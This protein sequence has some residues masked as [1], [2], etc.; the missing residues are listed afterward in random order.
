[1]SRL[2]I[3]FTAFLFLLSSSLW[4]HDYTVRIKSSPNLAYDLQEAI[5]KAKPNTLILLPEGTYTF[6]D[7]IT[8]TASH[9]TLRGLGM[10]KTVLSFKNQPAG[11]QGILALA[12]ALTVEDLAIEDT[13]GDGLR[14]EGAKGVTIRRTRVE[15]TN[16][17]S[18]FNGA[19]GL[20]PVLS[21]NVL[22]EDSVVKGASDAGIYVGQS[23]HIVVR[24]NRAEFNVAGIEIEN[25][26]HA[27]VYE[28]H[29][30][31][32]T[33]GILIFDLPNLSQQGNYT[34]VYNNVIKNN[35]TKNFAPQ[36]NIVGNVPSGT[37]VM[38]LAT[39]NVDVF[40]NKIIGNKTVG[41]LIASYVALAVI[42]GRPIP[43]GYDP[44][45][46][47]INIRENT[48]K[49]PLGFYFDDTDVNKL[50]NFAHYLAFSP[51]P[52]IVFDGLIAS[53]QISPEICIK[54]NKRLL[55]APKFS[56]LQLG[57]E[58]TWYG[59]LI[60]I[61]GGPVSKDKKPYRCLNNP[62]DGVT[63]QPPI[64]VPPVED[65]YSE[66]E[67]AALCQ[68]P[69][70]G[71][72]WP[73]LVV[74]C[75]NLSDYR[76]FA[77]SAEPRLDA[78]GGGFPYDLTTPLFSD[79]ASKYRFLF[80][81]PNQAINYNDMSVL[82]FPEGSVIT[83]TFAIGDDVNASMNDETLLETRLLIKRKNGWK[84]LP[85]I[86]NEDQTAARLALG[87]G[88]KAI[89][90][91]DFDGNKRETQYG[92]PNANQCGSCH[93][94]HE[95]VKPIGPKA[96]LLNMPSPY[97]T[98]VHGSDNNQL[99]LMA[100][101]GLLRGLP[102]NGAWP[103]TAQ[104]DNPASGTLE[105]RAKAYLDVN[106]AH[107]HSPGGRAFGTGL[108]LNEEQAVD[109]RYGL[110]KSPVAAGRGS[111]GLSF[112]IAPGDPFASIL[113]FRMDSIDPAIR[114]PELGR[115]LNHN[116]A[117]ALIRDWITSLDAECE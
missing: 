8:I 15:W 70:T 82:D 17:P 112:D 64:P 78:N 61:P 80:V 117:N 87:G 16:G 29:T 26:I 59:E 18:E 48:I 69:G 63:L 2:G 77:N 1:M 54:D 105:Q 22:I 44:Y 92:I 65:E 85:Y 102:A 71:V 20:Y 66:E 4:A 84:A 45:P 37:G 14:V 34:R 31:N 91:I 106:C 101:R 100:D 53:E 93:S 49:R 47:F 9:L 60:G 94:N 103:R 11:A 52:E 13:A 81:P 50:I 108:L 21:E 6:A 115:T 12:D 38:V 19:Y 67:I 104:W 76:L 28:N 109:V 86:W 88:R 89:S 23:K 79:F 33:G 114:M 24:R 97:L 27:D 111:G 107:C 43:P 73:A 41:V 51:V 39:D 110:C 62:F 98:A 10:N 7:E 25:S 113:Y 32:N 95:K 56:N 55:L 90:F 58:G 40:N 116:R 99:R 57:S 36:G 72:N 30:E 75:P 83:K 42:D 3:V 74:D 46:E 96:R 35:N 5:I 68:A